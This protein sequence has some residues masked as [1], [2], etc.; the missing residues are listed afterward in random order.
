MQSARTPEERGNWFSLLLDC[1]VQDGDLQVFP[2]AIHL[3]GQPAPSRMSRPA[4]DSALCAAAQHALLTL[5]I[6]G[7]LRPSACSLHA[8]HLHPETFAWHQGMAPSGGQPQQ[9]AHRLLSRGPVVEALAAIFP[10]WQAN[11]ALPLAEAVCERQVLPPLVPLS[12][13]ERCCKAACR[14]DRAGASCRGCA[15][16]SMRA[17]ALT[18]RLHLHSLCLLIAP[19]ALLLLRCTS[20]SSSGTLSPCRLAE[21]QAARQPQCGRAWCS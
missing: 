10:I 13:S 15:C 9:A 20:C 19:Q 12:A 5:V 21:L 1:A 3:S 6:C 11:F 2:E 18:G 17:H 14:A 4:A 7:A 16:T 8:C